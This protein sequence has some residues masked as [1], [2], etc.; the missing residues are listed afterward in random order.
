MSAKTAAKS[1]YSV[2]P[3]VQMVVD[4]IDTLK[5]KT[6]RSLDEWI[7][8]IKKNGPAE[9]KKRIEW[10]KAKHKLGTNSAWWLA[11]RA[12][13]KG[14]EDSDP[15]QYLKAAAEYVEAMYAGPK[16]ALRPMHDALLR[17]GKSLGNDVLVCPCK[18]IVPL[19]RKHDFAQI[20]LTTRMRI[21]FGL[22]L[23]KYKG[24]PAKRLIDTG[25]LAKKDRITHRIPITTVEDVDED[26]QR[27]L[28]IAYELDE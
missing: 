3:G 22:A 14:T 13:G 7:K 15:E 28:T 9:M 20:R 24:K 26:A 18:T 6:G 17:I 16:S 8:E 4:W 21:D 10:L 25:G 11:E 1:I 27:W 19:Y 2:H 5:A 12:E 23:A